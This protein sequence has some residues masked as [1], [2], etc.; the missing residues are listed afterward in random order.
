MLTL[1]LFG[2]CFEGSFRQSKKGYE[3]VHVPA[4]KQPPFEENE[5]L[6]PISSLPDWAQPAFE[7]IKELNRIQSRL[8]KAAFEGS[9]NILLCAPT[10]SGKTN[11]AMLAILHEIG[12]NMDKTTKQ[13]HLDD[14]KIIYIAPMKSLVQEMVHNFG[15]RLKSYGIT[16]RELTGDQS[17]TKKQISETQV[18][19]TTPEKWD[20]ITRKSGE[21]A[22]TQLVR[23]LIIDEIHLLHDDRGP[24]LESIIARTIRQIESTQEMIRLVGLSATLP[25][26]E[27]VARLLRVKPENLFPFANSYRPIP[28][29]Q[30]FIGIIT[31][32]LSSSSLL[33]PSPLSFSFTLHTHFHS[34]IL[35]FPCTLLISFCCNFAVQVSL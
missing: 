9:D 20:I 30:T 21:R 26:Y 6:I 4:Q 32:L 19:V 10:G 1:P 8:Y 7:G 33:F 24:V 17:L 12:L 5:H 34:L 28:L 11:V 23:L 16:V 14:F 2:F 22:Y 15:T 29:E 3:E 31:L 25:N 18:I 13:V 35:S 27:D